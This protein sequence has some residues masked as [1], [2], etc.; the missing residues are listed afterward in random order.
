MESTDPGESQSRVRHEPAP[1]FSR[2][3]AYSNP[4]RYADLLADVPRDLASVCAV[5]RNLIA[6]YWF[7]S[8]PLPASSN[9]DI[10][11]RWLSRILEIDQ[12][13]HGKPLQHERAEADR[14]QGCCRDQVL[15]AVGILRQH[16]VPARS[17]LG[18]AE[19]FH[20]DRRQ[21]HVVA[22]AWLGGR[23]VRFD[24]RLEGPRETL[25]DPHDISTALDSPFL[26]AAAAWI[27]H[28]QH[29]RSIDDLG[30]RLPAAEFMGR[31]CCT[32]R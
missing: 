21:D 12:Q 23:W 11:A 32:S 19:Y 14:V 30:V 16:G 13:R 17:R 4:G 7:A 15:L 3:S 22:E 6:H 20:G 5:A 2:H 29:G 31:V 8:G 1:H 26:T 18:F 28:R 27:G 10:N 9:D 25:A 24:P